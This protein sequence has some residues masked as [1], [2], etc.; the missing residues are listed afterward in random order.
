MVAFRVKTDRFLD[1]EIKFNGKSILQWRGNPRCMMSQY[2]GEV[3]KYH[4]REE[5][6]VHNA[7]QCF[8]KCKEYQGKIKASLRKGPSVVI[9]TLGRPG[10]SNN[11]YLNH[12]MGGDLD[13]FLSKTSDKSDTEVLDIIFNDHWKS[14]PY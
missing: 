11:L 9:C 5:Y 6:P 3:N 14:I 10:N 1:V 4:K 2:L 12:L 8:E 13:P 7:Q